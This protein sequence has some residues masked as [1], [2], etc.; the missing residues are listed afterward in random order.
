MKNR[1]LKLFI[2]LIIFAALLIFP[3]C[4]DTPD[5]PV[6]ENPPSETPP[7]DNPPEYE[8]SEQTPIEEQ[9]TINM[10]YSQ[11]CAISSKMHRNK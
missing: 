5:E 9:I 6:T 2:L 7:E 3:S 10:T 4:A 11:I 1:I 8:P